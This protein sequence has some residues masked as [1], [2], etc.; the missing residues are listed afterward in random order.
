MCGIFGHSINNV[1]SFEVEASRDALNTLE[2]RGPDQWGDWHDDQFYSGHRRLSILD[3]SDAG[4]QPMV[5]KLKGGHHVVMSAN[6]EIWNFQELRDVL[7]KDYSFQSES[8][9]EVLLHGYLAWGID[10]L[11]ERIDGMYAFSIYDSR[12]NKLYVVRDRFGI[13]PLYYTPP[14]SD[15]PKRFVYASEAKAILDFCPDLR[16]FSRAGVVDWLAHRG[17]YSGLTVFG[18]VHRVLPG[19]YLVYDI[20]S[21]SVD[22]VQYY[23][24]LDH[25]G[26][27]ACPR[28]L[29]S[30]FKAAVDRRLMAGVR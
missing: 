16:V 12:V 30:H 22:A 2:H 8:D 25:V 4:R 23:D 24:L 14:S 9:S 26:E 20:A 7:S 1:G 18:G 5:A 15:S 11:L 13:K 21:S 10:G 27:G 6:G 29:E 17:S 28:E 3:L 19:H